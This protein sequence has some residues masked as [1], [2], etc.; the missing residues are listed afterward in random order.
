MKQCPYCIEENEEA[1]VVCRVCGRDL[2]APTPA[3]LSA[4]KRSVAG[5]VGLTLLSTC[6]IAVYIDNEFEAIRGLAFD[7]PLTFVFWWLVCTFLVWA[8]RTI[9]TTLQNTRYAQVT[10]WLRDLLL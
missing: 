1:A 9:E 4:W 3:K 2:P 6:G 7:L 8:W 10:Q 5:A